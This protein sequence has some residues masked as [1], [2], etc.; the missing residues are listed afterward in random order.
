[1]AILDVLQHEKKSITEHSQELERRLTN[2][3]DE[4]SAKHQQL[5]R[6]RIKYGR[7]EKKYGE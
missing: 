6:Q 7:L 5:S 1:M 4:L 3:R 2:E